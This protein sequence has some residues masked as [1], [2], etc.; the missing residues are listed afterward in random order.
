VVSDYVREGKNCNIYIKQ[1]GMEPPY[2][3][4][5]TPAR[6]RSP[7]WSPDGRFVAFLRE[8]SPDKAALILIPQ[9]GGRNGCWRK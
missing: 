6:E 4:T 9:R 3:L 5:V 7:V 2:R 1:I 8:A